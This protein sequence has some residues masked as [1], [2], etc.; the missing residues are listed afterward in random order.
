MNIDLILFKCC[1]GIT[2]QLSGVNLWEMREM[3]SLFQTFENKYA[4]K[5]TLFTSTQ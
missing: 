5:Y 4:N 3:T 2:E 1:G